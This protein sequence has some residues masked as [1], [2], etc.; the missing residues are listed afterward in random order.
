MKLTDPTSMNLKQLAVL[1]GVSQTTVS[2]A[3]NGYPEVS[4]STRQ[5]VL[6]MAEKHNYRP[7]ARAASLATGRAMAIGHVIPA[8]SHG[9]MVNPIFGEFIAGASQ[10]YSTHGYELM[11]KM[12]EPGNE[13]DTYRDIAAR[14]QVDGVIVHSPLENDPRVPLLQ[15]IRLP[16]VVHGRVPGARRPYSW[17]DT[18]NRRAFRQATKLLIDL[19]HRRIALIN[20]QESLSFSRYRLQGFKEALNDAALAP[21]PDWLA[22]DE[23]TETHGYRSASR[24]LDSPSAPSAFLVSSYVVA[25]GVRRAI[26]HA[27]LRMGED[28]SVIIHDDELSFF[29]NNDPEPQFTAIRS[30]VR[31]AG[32]RAAGMLLDLIDNPDSAPQT[33]LF[34]AKLTLGASTGPARSRPGV[35]DSDSPLSPTG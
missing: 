4:K 1:C 8:G 18:N 21:N 14:A 27:G 35:S 17:I 20:G 26:A 24:M 12:A 3:L 11:L 6:Q 23:L 25:L 28:V 33:H 2:R 29:Q 19:G 15:N 5:R 32:R 34:E 13:S 16:F 7:N 9:E 10:T 31:E 22:S 30:S